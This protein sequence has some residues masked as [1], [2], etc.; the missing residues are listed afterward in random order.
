[1]IVPWAVNCSLVCGNA[2]YLRCFA[3]L[4]D[5]HPV[6][7]AMPSNIWVY[8]IAIWVYGCMG[9]GP[10]P[11]PLF[12]WR[13]EGADSRFRT[14]ELWPTRDLGPVERNFTP[15]WT[16]YSRVRVE[17]VSEHEMLWGLFRRR[18]EGSMRSTTSLFPF[19]E[20][21]RDSEGDGECKFSLLKG[22]LEYRRTG[23][24]KSVRVLYLFKVKP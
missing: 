5:I 3:S 9:Y 7:V 20:T 10:R 8:L 1:M 11:T 21:L 13:R 19:L 24:Q 17:D 2:G 6:S 16:L 22:L 23:L 12:S 15:F 4:A 18:T 14:L